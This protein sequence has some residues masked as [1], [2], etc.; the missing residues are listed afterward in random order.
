MISSPT[1][2][3]RDEL[4]GLAEDAV[5][6]F[7]LSR[8]HRPIPD[9]LPE[10]LRRPSAVFVSIKVDGRLRGCMGTIRPRH[11]TLAHEVIFNAVQAASEDPRFHPVRADELA[12]LEI[13]VDVLSAIEPCTAVD[14]D[15]LR[16]GLLVES[17]S[18]RGLLLP[19]LPGVSTVE[20]QIAIAREKAGMAPDAPASLFRFRVDRHTR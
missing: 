2:H 17:G 20:R 3:A 19:D 15:P 14:L 10:S 7:V 16:Y 4:V 12:T 9:P 11:E 5:R 1:P 8:V 18:R 6:S 13:S